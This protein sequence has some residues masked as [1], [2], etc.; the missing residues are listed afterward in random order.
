MYAS[1]PSPSDSIPQQV[2]LTAEI[3]GKY[4]PLDGEAGA[5]AVYFLSLNWIKIPLNVA[6]SLISKLK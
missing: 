3:D 2:L 6:L 1:F 4:T 5:L